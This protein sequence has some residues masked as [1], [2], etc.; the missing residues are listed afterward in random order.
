MTNVERG[1]VVD[2]NLEVI[3]MIGLTPD[4]IQEATFKDLATHSVR[5]ALDEQETVI[6]NNTISNPDDAPVTNTNFHDMRII[7]AFPVGNIG[8]VYVDQYLRRGII[9]SNVV[10]RLRAFAEH[11]LTTNQLEDTPEALYKRYEAWR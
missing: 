6:T 7:V 8:A 9:T 4:D 1:L 10:E 2:T 3:S 5:K 11:C